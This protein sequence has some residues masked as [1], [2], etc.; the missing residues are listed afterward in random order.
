VRSFL[1]AFRLALRAVARS[2][3]R[4]SLTILGILIG[5]AAVVIVVALG[6]GVRERVLKEVDSLGANA[7]YV[8]PQST[9]QSGVRS[10][11][12]GRLTEA[13]GKAMAQG[14]NSVLAVAPFSDKKAQVVVGDLNVQTLI[15]GTTNEYWAVRKYTFAEG[16]SWSAS[17]EQLKTRVCVLG[18]TVRQALFGNGEAVGRSLCIGRHTYRILGVLTKKG[19]SPWGRDQDDRIV[20]PIG[21]F[22]ARI[23]PSG[24]GQVQLLIASATDAR[25]VGRATIQMEEI[26][27]QRHR[28][29]RDDEADFKIFTQAQ[30]QEKQEEIYNA[31][32]TLL[33][34]IAA[35]SLLVGGIGVMNIML[36]SVAQRTREIGIR[37]AIG[38]RQGDILFQFLVEAVT[39]SLIGGICGIAL[40]LGVTRVLTSALDWSMVVPPMAIV[41]AVG[42]SA[43]I[44]VTFGYLPARRAARLDPID[45]LRQE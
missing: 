43:A 39:L 24:P 11:S 23:L 36:V 22:R 25:T 15:V 9:R 26:L 14:A 7:V 34:S 42:T 5:V 6:A 16:D 27:R 4:A 37:L 1:D 8:F 30:F 19:A 41:I 38:A 20:M 45:A 3:L 44:G 28:I 33:V 32:S 29:A 17:D 21:S 40:G 13:D 2:K 31:L 10:E 35:V 18:E 12:V